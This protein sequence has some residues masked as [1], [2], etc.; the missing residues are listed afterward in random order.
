MNESLNIYSHTGQ[1]KFLWT[2]EIANDPLAMAVTILERLRPGD[3]LTIDM[4]AI[5][6]IDFSFAA[7]LFGR[8]LLR[9]KSEF[10][11]RFVVVRNLEPVARENL[12]VTLVSLDLV[13]I[14][15]LHGGQFDLLGK[16]HPLDLETFRIVLDHDNRLTSRD[17]QAL[18]QLAANTANERLSKL[19][20][21]GL[22]RRVKGISPAGRQEFSYIALA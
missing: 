7:G 8:L 11:E 4:A 20:E 6:A 3:I 18:K 2:R 17:L 9:A 16:F 10:P 14:E 21:L 5:D 22:V 12:A 15:S 1:Q 19:V 13:M